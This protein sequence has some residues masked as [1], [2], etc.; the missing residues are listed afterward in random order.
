MRHVDVIAN[1]YIKTLGNIP[2]FFTCDCF[3]VWYTLPMKQVIEKHHHWIGIVGIVIMTILLAFIALTFFPK[4]TSIPTPPADP[5]ITSSV[6]ES[7]STVLPPITVSVPI[8]TTVA[9]DQIITGMAPGYYFF[10]GSFPVTLRDNNDQPF[11]T[12]IAKTDEDW[13]VTQTVSFTVTLPPTFS[14]TGMGSIL[15]KKDDP[16]DGEA[17]F[18]PAQDQYILPV[19]FGE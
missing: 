17:P 15:F 19:F 16:S 1:S 3:L 10:E 18:D 5:V 12:V 14:Y 7:P 2:R 4:K 6:S 11:A 13:M 9:P 8:A